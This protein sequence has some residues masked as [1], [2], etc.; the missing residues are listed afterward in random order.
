[1]I[2]IA[3]PQIGEREKAAV[4]EVLD[5]G[6]LAQGPR[7]RA[8]E[9]H[10]SGWVG[11]DFGVAV[12]NGTASLHVA[13]LAHGIGPGH[14]VITS[15]FTFVASANSILFVGAMP[16]FADIGADTFNLDPDSVAAHITERTRAILAV[17]LFGHPCDM[18]GLAE[19]ARAHDLVLIEDA[20]QAH[21]AQ[22][23]GLPMGSWGTA[24]YS[25]YP[26]K[27][28]TTAEG[29]MLTTNDPEIAD[30]ARLLRE[31]GSRERYLHESLGYNLRMTDLQAA[32][33]LIQLESVDAWNEQRRRNAD[34]LTAGLAGIPGLTT[35]TVRPRA[36]HVF[37]QY[38]IRVQARDDVR[39]ALTHEGIGT[40]IYYPIPVHQQPFY[41]GLGYRDK[42]PEAERASREVLSLP[43]HPSL[44]GDELDQIIAA[45][46]RITLQAVSA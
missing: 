12:S 20:C 4:L 44:T 27:N 29:G 21:G 43:V 37:H 41:T 18:E 16:V 38:T 6:Q 46:S 26:T 28:M 45:L 22:L 35:P 5:S 33:G 14:E 8:F 7:V 42:L 11:A 10:F 1:M 34:R 24:C 30:R 9:E 32:I 40:G 36:K 15:P 13:L 3:R 23:D 31:H 2:P 17:H 39:E 25:F 19:L